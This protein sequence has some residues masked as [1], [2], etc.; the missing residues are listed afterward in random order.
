[1][2][3]DTDHTVSHGAGTDPWMGKFAN[4]QFQLFRAELLFFSL[5][6]CCTDL[7]LN[8]LKLP[9]LALETV[10]K[11]KPVATKQPGQVAES[12]SMIPRA[13]NWYLLD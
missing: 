2:Q 10:F 3:D 6:H 8:F 9:V 5:A 13:P 1:M 12:A 4:D 7:R 11:D